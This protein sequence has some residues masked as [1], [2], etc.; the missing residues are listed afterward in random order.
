MS[1]T[2]KGFKMPMIRKLILLGS[3]ILAVIICIVAT[4]VTEYTLNKVSPEKAYESTIQETW[5]EVSEEDFMKHFTTFSMTESKQS[6]KAMVL[7]KKVVAL[8]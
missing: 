4:Y 2:K 6:L 1:N 3:I 7:S 5:V 8:N